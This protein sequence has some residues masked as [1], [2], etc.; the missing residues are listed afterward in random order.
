MEILKYTED[1]INF[2]ERV[3]KLLEFQGHSSTRY[4]LDIKS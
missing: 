4:F 2:R 1:H 3:R